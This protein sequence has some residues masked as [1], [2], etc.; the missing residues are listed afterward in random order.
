MTNVDDAHQA[1][2]IACACTPGC[3][4]ESS[5]E[6]RGAREERA[7]VAAH[8]RREGVDPLHSI[9]PCTTRP[10]SARDRTGR[11]S[12][13]EAGRFPSRARADAGPYMDVRKAPNTTRTNPEGGL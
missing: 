6:M 4:A 10:L 11:R 13:S 12:L 1:A 3:A 7:W 8:A 2:L 5:N 9:A